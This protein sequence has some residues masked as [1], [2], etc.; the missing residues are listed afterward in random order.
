MDLTSFTHGGQDNTS[1]GL[2]NN[3][4]D[5]LLTISCRQ[6]TQTVI[7]DSRPHGGEWEPEECGSFRGC[8]QCG[9]MNIA[10][11]EALICFDVVVDG[12]LR[13][14]DPKRIL[15]LTI[16]VRYWT[17]I[18]IPST[19]I[20][21]S[22][23]VVPLRPPTKR[24][25][26]TYFRYTA[27]QVAEESKNRTFDFIII[28]SGIGGGVLASSLLEKNRMIIS[29]SFSPHGRHNLMMGFQGPCG[30][31][32]WTTISH[33]FLEWTSSI[34]QEWSFPTRSLT[35]MSNSRLHCDS[36]NC[37][38]NQSFS[39]GVQTRDQQNQTRAQVGTKKGV[40]Q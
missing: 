28:G 8:F 12:T 36:L 14:T 26:A 31:A 16:R 29:Q 11:I 10:V 6:R 30:G 27:A 3:G 2:L 21:S 37:G 39:A 40:A 23:S 19:M 1:L 5:V 24:Y 38:P 22:P 35:I 17:K 18:Y 9:R 15:L 13:D 32:R 33:S 7:Y 4:G 34:K 20:W 25:D